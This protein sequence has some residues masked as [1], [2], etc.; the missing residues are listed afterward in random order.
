MADL[1]VDEDHGWF[2]LED[3]AAEVER[4]ALDPEQLWELCAAGDDEG[5]LSLLRGAGWDDLP[6]ARRGRVMMLAEPDQAQGERFR[7]WVSDD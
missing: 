5:A 2:E 7:V 4:G 3:F 6:G 1:F